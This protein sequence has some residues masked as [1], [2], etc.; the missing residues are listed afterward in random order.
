MAN[1]SIL[2]SPGSFSLPEFYDV[3]LNN[4]RAKGY[5][6]QCLHLPTVGLR[7]GEGREG[8]P[9][10]MYDDAA[11]IAKEAGRLADEGKDV[12]LIGH[13][14]GGIPVTESIKGLTTEER[15]DQK[16]VG[17]VI[18]LAYMTCLVP[19]VGEGAADVLANAPQEQQIKLQVDV[20]VAFLFFFI[21]FATASLT[22][23]LPVL[24][25]ATGKWMVVP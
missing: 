9:A 6:I 7:T 14:Y 17:G 5:E 25:V 10:T 12:I 4:V 19:A 15:R 16:K 21:L 20:S 22:W 11:F 18:H 24:I 1:S 3:I 8:A 13:S 23:P 2:F